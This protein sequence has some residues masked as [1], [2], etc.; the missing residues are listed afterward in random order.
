MEVAEGIRLCSAAVQ[1][2]VEELERPTKFSET[3]HK[4]YEAFSYMCEEE[5]KKKQDEG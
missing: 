1:S 5:V 3:C 2:M 4:R